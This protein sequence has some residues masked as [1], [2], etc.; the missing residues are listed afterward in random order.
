M[1][2]MPR[3]AAL[4]FAPAMEPLGWPKAAECPSSAW[5]EHSK[6]NAKVSKQSE[7]IF[8]TNEA[9]PFCPSP[10]K[11]G[12]M[13]KLVSKVTKDLQ[14]LRN[15]WIYPARDRNVEDQLRQALLCDSALGCH[16]WVKLLGAWHWPSRLC[17]CSEAL[18]EACGLGARHV[19]HVWV[20]VKRNKTS[21]DLKV[22]LVSV[23]FSLPLCFSWKVSDAHASCLCNEHWDLSAAA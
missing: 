22:R 2:G 15:R 18:A 9:L 20:K 11:S 6:L 19:Q 4:G 8:L 21:K 3:M 23:T 7:D 5:N 16:P 17:F 1:P 12:K 14:S 13:A 10:L